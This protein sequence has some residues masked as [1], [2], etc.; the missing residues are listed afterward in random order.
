MENPYELIYLSRTGDEDAFPALLHQIEP[1]LKLE[2]NRLVSANT[3]FG[4]Y[5]ED[6]LMESYISVYDAVNCYREDMGTGFPTFCMRVVRNRLSCFVRRNVSPKTVRFHRT[7]SLEDL[8]ME[9][10]GEPMIPEQKDRLSDP[11]YV[12]RMN[13]ASERL[14]N[15]VGELS[16]HDR[17]VLA[18]WM[19]G[20]SY[21]QAGEDLRM[22][23]RQFGARKERIRKMVLQTVLYGD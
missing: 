21:R 1:L 2:V 6:M 22:T 10:D 7:V 5:R 3:G 20:K 19:D 14:K 9:P 17:E 12:L 13:Q 15:A 4:I 18:A 8:V 16:G 23:E 11:E